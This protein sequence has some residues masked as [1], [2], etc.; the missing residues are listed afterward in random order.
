MSVI[1]RLYNFVNATASNAD[2]VDA[3]FDQILAFLNSNVVHKDGTVAMT[4]QLI[5]T[6]NPTVM[7][8]AAPK[9]YVDAMVTTPAL[10]GVVVMWGG[11]GVPVGWLECNGQAVSRAV[12]AT[13][14]AA[15]STTHGAGDGS[16]TFN[17]PDFRGRAPF[18]NGTM[19]P[20][21]VVPWTPGSKWGSEW[22][23]SH[24]HT[25]PSIYDAQDTPH[26]HSGKAGQLSEGSFS[27]DGWSAANAP[28]SYT[29]SGGSENIPPGTGII[30]IIKT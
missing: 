9:Q 27:A 23:Q 20:G 30:F 18:G 13:L 16:T 2:Q 26:T 22:L 15:V 3:E 19:S 5:L 17:V 10:P 21:G 12:Y 8:G 4:G 14:F 25:V 29:G 11:A 1:T 6:G 7:L 24:L 28:T